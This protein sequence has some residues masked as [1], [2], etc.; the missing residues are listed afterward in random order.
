MTSED[1]F[2]Y[3]G[4]MFSTRLQGLLGAQFDKIEEEHLSSLVEHGIPESDE[5]D[6]KESQYDYGKKGVFEVSKDAAAFANEIGGLII[7]GIRESHGVAAELCPLNLASEVEGNMS[8]AW[9]Q[10]VF[11]TIR[12]ILTRRVQSRIFPGRVYL[13]VAVPRSAAAP[14]GVLVEPFDRSPMCW[15][16]RTGATT[17]FLRE[18]ELASRYRDRFELARGQVDR[19]SR[20]HD[21]GTRHAEALSIRA[22]TLDLA[23]APEM[24]LRHPAHRTVTDVLHHLDESDIGYEKFGLTKASGRHQAKRRRVRVTA[25]HVRWELYTDG[26]VWMRTFVGTPATTSIGHVTVDVR[27]L[28]T[29][30][31]AMLESAAEF[32]LWTGATGDCAI[33]LRV[34]GDTSRA[35]RLIDGEGGPVLGDSVGTA[36]N[37]VELTWSLEDLATPAGARHAAYLLASDLEQDLGLAAPL[38]GAGDDTRA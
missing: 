26:A 17:R 22:L 28:E 21:D 36:I 3:D 20:L 13:L 16:A 7:L 29:R 25:G 27:D 33:H 37:P 34:N 23:F 11:P 10:K 14:H 12:N 31:I 30:L 32:S 8:Q 18:G 1:A 6:F 4:S 9:A 19:L 38:L 35:L 24:N 5:L 2:I 15:P